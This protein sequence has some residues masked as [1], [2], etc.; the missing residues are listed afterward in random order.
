MLHL[1][2]YIFVTLVSEPSQVSLFEASNS[3][4]PEVV[5]VYTHGDGRYAY[6][7]TEGELIGPVVDQLKCAMGALK[8]EYSIHTVSMRR[9]AGLAEDGALDMWFPAFVW[10]SVKGKKGEIWGEIDERKLYWFTL[11]ESNLHPSSGD[12]KD[13]AIVSSFPGSGPAMILQDQAYNYVE[14]TDDQNQ[15]IVKLLEGEIDAVFAL[16]FR[17]VLAPRLQESFERIEMTEYATYRVG[18]EFSTIFKKE[19]PAFM[20]PF[21]DTLQACPIS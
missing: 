21:A 20:E 5:R 19:Y 7:N 17:K 11:K 12:F 13:E 1:I 3:S 2:S 16:D 4:S 14:T 10:S 6:Y 8:Q 18:Y 15:L 9:A